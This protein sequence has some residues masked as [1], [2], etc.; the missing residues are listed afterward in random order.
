MSSFPTMSCVIA[1][2]SIAGGPF[3]WRHGGQLRGP[4]HGQSTAPW[5]SLLV[6]EFVVNNDTVVDYDVE[7]DHPLSYACSDTVRKVRAAVAKKPVFGATPDYVWD[8]VS[9]FARKDQ[10]DTVEV[11]WDA[12][13]DF[14]YIAEWEPCSSHRTPYSHILDL[15]VTVALQEKLQL[16]Q[17]AVCAQRDWDSG[18]VTLAANIEGFATDWAA[19]VSAFADALHFARPI[20]ECTILSAM[21]FTPPYMKAN[22]FRSA[23]LDSDFLDAGDALFGGESAVVKENR[24]S[25]EMLRNKTGAKEK[26]GGA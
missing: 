24:D 19:T 4:Q 12:D 7:H 6:V 15:A 9:G 17:P 18:T 3:D 22:A 5:A 11:E 16:T 8:I 1:P 2:S 14:K 13:T 23:I 21:V 26:S 20:G 25:Y 10:D